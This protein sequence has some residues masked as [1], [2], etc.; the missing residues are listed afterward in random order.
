MP[1]RAAE[2]RLLT[3]KGGGWRRWFFGLLM[4]AALVGA[5]LH[6]GEIENFGHLLAR[7]R[8]LRPRTLTS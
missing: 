5:V 2:Q 4:T 1:S 8:H 6:F 3:P 7:A